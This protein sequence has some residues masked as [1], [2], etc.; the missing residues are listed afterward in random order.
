MNGARKTTVTLAIVLGVL[1]AATG[2]FVTLFL[3]ERAAAAE[4][5][6]Q[7]TVRERE[8]DG[9]RDRLATVKSTVDDLADEELDLVDTGDALRACADPAK[10]A[11]DAA[12]ADN[13]QALS[14]AVDE[15]LL[16]CGR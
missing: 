14:D 12:R 8:L 13:K 3:L 15:M 10:A 11:L 7:V 6:G 4:V 16:H 2:V 9:A 5:G 1:V